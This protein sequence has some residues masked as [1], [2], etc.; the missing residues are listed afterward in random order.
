MMVIGRRYQ[1]EVQIIQTGAV[2][3]SSTPGLIGSPPAAPVAVAHIEDERECLDRAVLDGQPMIR[4]SNC[5]VHKDDPVFADGTCMVIV[6]DHPEPFG[7]HV[8]VEVEPVGILNGDVAS[9][10]EPASMWYDWTLPEQAVDEPAPDCTYCL[11]EHAAQY[12]KDKPV[13]CDECLRLKLG[14]A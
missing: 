1:G 11:T 3:S 9:Q 2:P 4:C 10:P 12:P 6:G 5:G 8:W 14:L 13:I 7:A